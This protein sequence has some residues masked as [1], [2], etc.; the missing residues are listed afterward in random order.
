MY[1][2]KVSVFIKQKHYFILVSKISKWNILRI[3]NV[4]VYFFRVQF[5]TCNDKRN[6]IL[7][8]SDKEVEKY[9]FILTSFMGNDNEFTAA[10]KPRG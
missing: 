2:L 3:Q 9:S 8:D 10:V 4:G 1:K 5:H 7:R 6:W